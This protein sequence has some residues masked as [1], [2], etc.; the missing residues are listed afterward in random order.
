MKNER[1][2]ASAK[3]IVLTVTAA[4]LLIPGQHPQRSAALPEQTLLAEEPAPYDDTPVAES[5][6]SD[7]AY[8]QCCTDS[9]Q[10]VDFNRTGG[11]AVR[12]HLRYGDPL[13]ADGTRAESH[14]GR[15]P[16]SHFAAGDEVYYGFSIYIKGDWEADSTE[17]IVFQWHT[18]PDACESMKY[19]S[20]F[21]SIQPGGEW[22]LRVN[23][24]DDACSTYE[25]MSR[26]GFDLAEVKPGQWHDFVFRFEWDYTDDGAI[27]VWHQ[28][29]K[30]P[31]WES[32]LS[33]TG[34]NT[35]NDE[36]GVDG[37]LK[38]GIYKPAWNLAPTDVDDR[39]I[40]HD[41][42]A[43]GDSFRAVDPSV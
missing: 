6:Q 12:S 25:S 41:N 26:T 21:L 10:A 16:S 34:P 30:D 19:P 2:P 8:H 32:V 3:A 42:V 23:S 13:V 39:V 4:L 17:E 40:V 9:I 18:R 24:D 11:P 43:F 33:T 38:W 35:Y 37:Y 7:L 27:Q 5:W 14:T 15:I 28:T 22:R 31:G 20:A 29:H 36:P 1:F